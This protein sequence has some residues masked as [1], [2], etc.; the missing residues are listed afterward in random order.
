MDIATKPE[1]RVKKIRTTV[2]LESLVVAKYSKIKPRTTQTR[3]KNPILRLAFIYLLPSSGACSGTCLFKILSSISTI[4]EIVFVPVSETV[5][6][7]DKGV[8]LGPIPKVPPSTLPVTGSVKIVTDA[9]P[10]PM[11]ILTVFPSTLDAGPDTIPIK[12]SPPTLRP[13]PVPTLIKV[14]KSAGSPPNPGLTKTPPLISAP[15]PAVALP[16]APITTVNKP[17]GSA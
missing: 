12:I 15:P 1:T 16:P 6:V 2:Y 4:F 7:P 14:P 11:L 5:S 13:P 17:L 10:A 9:G 3:Y 8:A